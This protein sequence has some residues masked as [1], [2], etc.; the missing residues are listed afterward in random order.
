MYNPLLQKSTSK[1]DDWKCNCSATGCQMKTSVKGYKMKMMW[2]DVSYWTW[3][4]NV[5]EKK[6]FYNY[7]IIKTTLYIMQ[8]LYWLCYKSEQLQF[9]TWSC[10]NR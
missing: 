4:E 1:K 9:D 2:K 10:I 7:T 3:Q 8:F 6:I 5:Q